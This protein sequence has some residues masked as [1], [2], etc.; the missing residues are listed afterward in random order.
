[1]TKRLWFFIVLSACLCLACGNEKSSQLKI[2][3]IY[4]PLAGASGKANTEW[5]DSVVRQF[6]K[7]YPALD[8]SLEQIQWDQI[9]SKSMADH[10][11]GIAHDVIWTSP[12]LMPK[13]F[14]VRDLK[15]LSPYI[16]W[17][18][19]ET[20]DFAWNP[21]WGKSERDGKR[22]GIPLGV[23]TRTVAYRRDMFHESNLNP[24]SPPQNLEELI[25]AAKAL[26]VDTDGDGK[27]DVWGL[28]IYLGP[29]RATI[30]IS[31][32]PLIWHFGGKLWDEQSKRAWFRVGC[33]R[34]GR[35]IH[36]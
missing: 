15:N 27:P 8:I 13:H 33:R 2:A 6:Q 18:A 3:H 26:T 29:H 7:K 31:F 10:H 9:D 30:E 1:M 24:D 11:A 32:A 23:H 36:L 21:V 22:M 35:A 20:E 5:L 16:H 25:D 4:D 17:T 34:P 12:Q 28:G 14:L 19:S